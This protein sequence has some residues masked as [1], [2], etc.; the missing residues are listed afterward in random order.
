MRRAWPTLA[1][2][3]ALALGGGCAKLSRSGQAALLASPLSS[4][5]VGLEIYSVR[6]PLGEEEVNGPL[7]DEVDEQQLPLA[8]RRRLAANGFRVGV[9]GARMPEKLARILKLEVPPEPSGTQ[10][11]QAASESV[12]LEKEPLVRRRVMQVRG[13]RKAQL[14]CTGE[15]V[16][17]A[18]LPVLV[19]G[20]DG[21]VR[22]RTYQRVMGLLATKAFPEGDGRVRL[23]LVP[24]IEH[25]EPQ[26]RF[27]PGEGMLRM[28]FGPPIERFD[29]LRLEAVL[30][31]G[32]V[33]AL[34][35]LPERA[36]SLGYQFF[37]ETTPDRVVQKLLLVRLAQTQYDDLFDPDAP[38][39][40]TE[41]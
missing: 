4:R 19:R 12:D 17:H 36:G 41:P 29:P 9:I 22:G 16:R 20:D 18:S 21:E 37:T 3:C 7:W 14:I 40:E 13:G 8:T 5:N 11:E 24:E 10:P 2:S 23:E 1:I 30:A 28:E 6:V 35:C 33:L 38:P 25:G 26:R 32:Q 27:D 31:P 15:T 34:T 39:I